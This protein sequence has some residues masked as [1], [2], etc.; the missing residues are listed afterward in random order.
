MS[1]PGTESPAPAGSTMIDFDHLSEKFNNDPLPIWQAMRSAD[2]VWSPH[3]GGFHVLSRYADVLAG[4]TM[5]TVLSSEQD[6]TIPTEPIPPFIPLEIDPPAHREYRK[7]L[8]VHM[9]PDVV[10]S[11]EEEIRALAVA[12]FESICDQ[13]TADLASTIA[14]PLPKKV[15]LRL[16]GI[17]DADFAKVDDWVSH[18]VKNDEVAAEM[19]AELAAYLQAFVTVRRSGP[20]QDDLTGAVLAGT[21]EGEPL[22]DEAVL[23]MILLLIF[24]GLDTTSSALSGMLLWLAENPAGRRELRQRPE[25]IPTAVDE[26]IRITCPVTQMARTATEDVTVGACP[27]TNGRKVML[28]F[29]AANRDPSVFE[30]PD[31]VVFDRSPN[32]HLSFGAGPHRCVGSHYA[33][34]MVRIVLEESLRRLGDFRLDAA[35]PLTWTAGHARQLETLPVALEGR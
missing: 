11:H 15:A 33:R 12:L 35:E 1:E 14:S 23:S 21:L 34:L 24:G 16:I 27:I 28:A 19:G 29:G 22:T 4:A 5:P 7:I 2:A 10:A 9:S 20:P 8:N 25:L 26:F 31:M 30:D 13:P 32:R 6:V 17:P 18:V 3:Y